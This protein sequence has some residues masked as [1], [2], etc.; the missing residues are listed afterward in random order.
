MQTWAKMFSPA[1]AASSSLSRK[2][3]IVANNGTPLAGRGVV[4]AAAEEDEED[5][6]EEEALVMEQE[7]VEAT[8][9]GGEGGKEGEVSLTEEQGQILVEEWVRMEYQLRHDELKRFGEE[10]KIGAFVKAAA[11]ARRRL[12]EDIEVEEEEE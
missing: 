10:E 5:E 11:E 6:E 3:A 9:V 4:A 7:A 12:V 2:V 1:P 8:G